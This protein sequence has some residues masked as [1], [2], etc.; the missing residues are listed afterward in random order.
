MIWF[1]KIETFKDYWWS[2]VGFNGL[3]L[4]RA[5][6]ILR[7]RK[8]LLA[9]VIRHV[10]CFWRSPWM[11]YSSCLRSLN[12]ENEKNIGNLKSCHFRHLSLWSGR[13]DTTYSSVSIAASQNHL[14]TLFVVINQD[15]RIA[16]DA[17]TD[18][19]ERSTVRGLGRCLLTCFYF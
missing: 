9:K 11:M 12:H 1:I 15:T 2:R 3:F 4:T 5:N 6:P 18:S 7:S 10:F 13:V 14:N 16:T 19:L 8:F 17:V